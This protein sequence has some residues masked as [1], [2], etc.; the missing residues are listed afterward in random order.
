[1]KLYKATIKPLS[2]FA[3]PIKGDT[4][5]G[6]LCWMIVYKYGEEKLK[7]L[8]KQYETTPFLVVSDAF[9]KGYLPKPKMP[10]RYLNENPEEKKENRKKIWLTLEDLQEGKFNKAKKDEEVYKNKDKKVIVIRNSINYKTF[11]TDG[12]KFAPYGVDEYFVNEKDVY[13]LLDE[14]QLS[15]GEL[16]ELLNYL[17]DFGYGKDTTI[18]KGRFEII[19]FRSVELDFKATTYMSL[20]PF[21]LKD[22]NIKE[23][24]YEPFVKF[25]KLGGDRVYTNAFKKPILMLNTGS[26]IVYQ[27]KKNRYFEGCAISG[28]STYKDVIHQGYTILFPIKDIL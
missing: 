16:T 1:M 13:F 7:S 27:N 19:D 11:T 23:V 25:G 24:F 10:S 18:G 28:I 4:F 3:S 26:V 22:Q 12:D 15:V 9:A 2:S 17:G 20:S 5:F 8:L 6:Q 14:N 21:A